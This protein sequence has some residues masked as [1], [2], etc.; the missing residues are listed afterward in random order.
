MIRITHLRGRAAPS[1]VDFRAPRLRIG[2]A[3]G[4]EI[5][6]VGEPG[7]AP[8]HAEIRREGQA[9]WLIDLGSSG[10]SYVNHVRV[11][12]HAIRSG[13]VVTFAASGGPQLQVDLP[14]AVDA[15][16]RVDLE[17]AQRL[18]HA[19]VIQAASRDDPTAEI[20][21]TKV[22]AAR[23]RGSR[24]NALLTLG[25]LV[26]L[27]AT[28]VAA[29]M[30]YRSQQAAQMLAAE[31]GI[32]NAPVARPQGSIPT[33]VYTGREIHEANRSALYV[34]GYLLP[35]DRVGGCCTGFAIKPDVLA[36]NAHCVLAYRKA[37][38]SPIVT[39]NDSGGK[40][41]FKIVA[42]QMHPGYKPDD[43]SADS[44]DV[45]LIRIAG[46]MPYTVTI[47]N[48]A[49]LRSLGPGDDVFVLGFPGRVMDPISPSLT[50]LQGHLG[51]TT[52]FDGQPT[53]PEKSMLVQ[54]DAV[55]RGGNSGSPVFNQYGHVIAVHAAHL[56]DEADAQVGGQKTKIVGSSAFRIAMR[57]DLL[58]GVPAP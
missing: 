42:S 4:N 52:G 24:A 34:I 9:F 58:Q 43:Q 37:G 8:L 2:A 48:D 7:V 5:P 26:A 30:V 11:V 21:A 38:G 28:L 33:R 55:T 3:P 36:T 16:G 50:F 53:S 10:G 14:G 27:G 57:I 1:V 47:A 51:R 12:R 54:H 20:I 46:K 13:D 22:G 6:L 17:T 40:A 25:L 18:V 39:Q 56:D 19:A 41:R 31:T 49:E 15:E 35:G 44:P 45:G 29:V 32:G 23:R